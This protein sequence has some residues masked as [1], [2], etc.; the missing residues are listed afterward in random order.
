MTFVVSECRGVSGRNNSQ[1][2]ICKFFLNI[3]KRNLFI[4]GCDCAYDGEKAWR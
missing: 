2:L 4:N 1:S 3:V